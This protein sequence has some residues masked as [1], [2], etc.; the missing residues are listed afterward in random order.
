MT[1]WPWMKGVDVAI[2]DPPISPVDKYDKRLSV[3]ELITEHRTKID[4]IRSILQSD[5][6]DLY[7]PT[8]HDDLWILRFVLS[9]HNKKGIKKALKAC[10]TTLEFRN[11]YS[12]V[13]ETD[14]R[15]APPGK[16]VKSTQQFYQYYEKNAIQHVSPDPKR[17]VQ[18]FALLTGLNM[19]ALVKNIDESEWLARWTYITEYSHQW[20]DYVTRTTGLL[21]KQIRIIDLKGIRTSDISMEANKRDGKAMSVMEDC[22]PQLLQGIFVCNSP[23]WV[24][25]TWRVCRP[26]MP[27]R[28]VQKLDFITPSTKMKEKQ[29]LLEHISEEH[30]PEQY[31]GK[32]KNNNNATTTTTTKQEESTSEVVVTVG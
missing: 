19:N 16:S 31:G 17:G 13:D 22:Y 28:V 2:A 6:K 14:I 21:T 11:K 26:L 24:Q 5:N 27:K 32:N 23:G 25:G 9:H 15:F 8:K 10:Q 30:L 18:V 3:K 20:L 12:W 29:R 1:S 4:E 7:N